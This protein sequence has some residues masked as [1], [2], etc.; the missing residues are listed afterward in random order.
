[1]IDQEIVDWCP[2]R[3]YTYR[4]R[5]PAG[6]CMWTIVLTPLDGGR[7]THVEWRFA[8]AGGRRQA[9]TVKII[10]GRVRRILQANFDALLAHVQEQGPAVSAPAARG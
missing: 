9:L 7:G 1:M 10:G 6:P 3:H 4:E 8:Y 5:N 2:P